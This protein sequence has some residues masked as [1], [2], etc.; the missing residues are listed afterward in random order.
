[1]FFSKKE[2]I[3]SINDYIPSNSAFVC[4]SSFESRCYTIAKRIDVKKIRMAY[5][6][7][8]I[9]PP[10]SQYNESSIKT[11]REAIEHIS[12]VEV[13]LNS[14]VTVA[15]KI[16]STIW[17]IINASITNIIIDIST[18]THEALLMLLKTLYIYCNSFNSILLVYNGAAEY[19][20]WLSK[21]CKEIRNVIGYPGSFN[22]SYK[23]YMIIL[24]GFEKERATMLVELFEPDV[25]SIGNGSEPTDRN[26]LG[27]MHEMK[28]EFDAWFN[29]L[30]TAWESFDFSC[31]NI[32]STAEKIVLEIN[33]REN[34]NIVLVPLNTKLSTI[35]AAIV[36]LK[37]EKIQVVYPVPEIYN[38][39]YSIPSD[40]FTIVNLKD[41]MEL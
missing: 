24:T 28:D 9:D 40:N 32:K 17:D 41:A 8:N 19:S 30:G 16:F 25:L 15:D 7:R 29:N 1:M 36:A 22:P 6:F 18:F 26:H 14:P 20:S 10:M 27:T 2:H 38:P 39:I 33:K 4:F 13:S 5:V 12:I 31:S 37:N 35:S 3:S 34:E 11:I 23:D 21:G